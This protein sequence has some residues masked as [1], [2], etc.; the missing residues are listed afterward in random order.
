MGGRALLAAAACAMIPA[1]SAFSVC[2][3]IG[4]PPQSL[5][6]HAVCGGGRDRR[7]GLLKLKVGA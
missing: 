6:E 2:P 7:A 5:R 3:G 1:V 4:M